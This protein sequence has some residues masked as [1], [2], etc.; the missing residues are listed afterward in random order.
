MGPAKLKQLW[1]NLMFVGKWQAAKSNYSS[2]ISLHLV[3]IN[4]EFQSENLIS[5]CLSGATQPHV[6]NAIPNKN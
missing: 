2:F 6:T 1:K 3:T 5:G 4:F